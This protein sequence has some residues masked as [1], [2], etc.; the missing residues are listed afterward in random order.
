MFDNVNMYRGKHKHLRLFKPAGPGMWN[1][2]CQ[3]ILVPDMTGLEENLQ[4]ESTCLQPQK[5]VLE[6]DLSEIF[7]EADQ[8][9][10]EMFQQVV[11]MFLLEL[12]DCALNKIPESD[13]KLKS[14]TE[15]QVNTYLAKAK[16]E[17]AS[18]YPI[19][20][21]PV[22]T[23]VSHKPAASKSEVDVLLLS[24]EDNSTIVG[25]MAILDQLAS[26]F[27]LPNKKKCNEYVPFDVVSKTW[28]IKMA[29]NHYEL[30]LSQ[31]NHKKYME[32]LQNQLHAK[33]QEATCTN[34]N[35]LDEDS[36][37]ESAGIPVSTTL[38]SER[39]QFDSEDTQFWDTYN[40][41]CSTLL[42]IYASNS[43]ERYV[44]FVNNCKK[45]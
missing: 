21:P 15:S 32:L 3:A 12:L 31:Q 9:K 1:F 24:L 30:I 10:R 16:Y 25:T 45:T 6:I 39:R 8:E 38:E 5:P 18:K 43:E 27:S 28:D 11:D 2:T 34:E 23:I 42:S 33:D 14:M 36:Q 7:V 20:I 17:T 26:D 22:H 44:H 4:H 19:N 35:V 40:M 13:R 37:V 41:F 29:R